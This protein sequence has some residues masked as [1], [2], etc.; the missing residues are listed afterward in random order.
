MKIRRLELQ[1]FKSFCDRTVFEFGDGITSVVGPNGCGKSNVVDSIKW[2]LG[3]MSPKSLRGKRMEDVIFAGS[4]GRKPAG[5]AEVTLVL[6]NTDGSLPNER[7]EVAITRRLYRSGESE[8]LLNGDAGRLKDIRELFL[9]T[10]L[11]AEG[12]SIMEQG[13]IDAL[14]RANSTDRRGIFEEAAGVSRYKQR[15]KEAESKLEKTTEN[16]ERMRD[17]LDLEEKR[18][19]SLK[20]QASRA[21]RYRELV[22]DLRRKKVT[23]AVLRWRGVT[24]ERAALEQAIDAARLREEA[25]AADLAALEAETTKRGEEK[26]TARGRVHELESAIAQAAG[27]A[28]AAED[29][30]AYTKRTLDDLRARIE[31]AR[32]LAAECEEKRAALEPEA[33]SAD[34][35]AAAGRERVV[36]LEADVAAVEADLAALEREAEA[37]RAAHE[38]AKR[39]VL[40]LLQRVS[41]ARN[42]E[43]ERR[44]EIRQAEARLARL[45]EQRADLKARLARVEGE[46]VELEAAAVR[47]DEAAASAGKALAEAEE[48]RARHGE[49]AEGAERRRSHLA[50]ERAKKAERL[51]VLK[52]MA[53][54]YEG[55]EGGAKLVLE[56][57]ARRAEGDGVLGLLA[58]RIEASKDG[59]HLLDRLLGHAAGA[60]LVR[61]TADAIRWLEWLKGRGGARARFLALDLARE[62]APSLPEAVGPVRGDDA[63]LRLVASAASGCVLV[64]DLAAGVAAW[65]STPG[66]TNAVT[67]SGDRVTASGALVN[68]AGAQSLGLVERAGEVR[69]LSDEVRALA[70]QVD[71]ARAAADQA[72]AALRADEETVRRLRQELARRAEDRSRHG[73]S[74][75]RVEKER[76]HLSD[77]LSV[78]ES[79]SRELDEAKAEAEVGAAKAHEE[80]SALEVERAAAEGNAAESMASFV[81]L[82]G[83]MKAVGE[84]RM[85]ARLA[86]GDARSRADAAAGRANRL[87]RDAALLAERAEGAR[88]EAEALVARVS[89]GEVEIAEAEAVFR[90]RDA[91]RR[92]DADLL[93]EARKAVDALDRGLL[94]ARSRTVEVHALH[95]KLREE[96][97]G[98]RR[99]EAEHR[100]RI[101]ALVEQV[102]SEHGVELEAAAADPTLAIPAAPV[103]G[104]PAEGGAAV[105]GAPVVDPATLDTE[106]ADLKLRIDELGNVNLN[107]ITEMEE[108]EQR[109]TFLKTQEKDLLDAKEQL[110]AAI[111]QLDQLSVTRFTETFEKVREHFRETFRRLF[112]GGRAEITLE[113]PNDVLESGIDIV[114]RP[115]GKEPRS[116]GLLSGGEKTL[117]AV[118]LLFAVFRA[119]P[120]P[121][122]ILDEVDA[123]LDEANIRRLVT[124]LSEFTKES[125]FLVVTHAKTTM[126]AADMLYGVTM[127]EPGVSKR[128]AVKLGAQEATAAG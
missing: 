4:A 17:V 109:V 39:A 104:A 116:I 41:R 10:G 71:E 35:E 87:R 85:T 2:A 1:G 66:G 14:L 63:V 37:V 58:D 86:V 12:H 34:A 81:V 94:D 31:A 92:R 42:A 68:G 72:R 49:E 18:L 113:N 75:A 121:F 56:E 120:S 54:A 102:R 38:G 36:A 118:A 48:A 33:A 8:Y 15:K 62:D 73:A 32:R 101:E 95:E 9:D 22:D 67:P 23:A 57:A 69:R 110:G 5:L 112:G 105:E 55:V 40:D 27:D 100:I 16:L 122:A 80:A 117:T 78:A 126:E 3:D 115:P 77:T 128:V 99:R 98:F 53:A 47:M 45:A 91:A 64:P 13:Q 119:K 52:R 106:I 29:R 107:A 111:V 89:A 6:D 123:A 79:E 97:D 46:A 93:V 108:A 84:R 20:T 70:A 82:E 11:G 90:D 114:A 19:R 125:Q 21:R 96:L 25:A 83:R 124:L 76:T 44:T 30:V 74:L 127:E 50:E 103:A 7:Q 24:A 28:R 61:T 60:I 88:T 65:R 26:E 43:T 59:A 51:D